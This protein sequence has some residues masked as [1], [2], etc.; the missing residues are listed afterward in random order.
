MKPIPADLKEIENYMK[1]NL[2]LG[3]SFDVGVRKAKSTKKRC[4][5]LLC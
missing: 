5:F 3:I 4:S 2:G 1:E